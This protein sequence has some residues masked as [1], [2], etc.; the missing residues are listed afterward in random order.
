MAKHV[1]DI[2]DRLRHY[3]GFQDR[4]EREVKT[5]LR[6]LGVPDSH[7]ETFLQMLRDEGFLDEVR[8]AHGFARGKFRM[9]K[10]G[11]VLIRQGLRQKGVPEDL[12]QTAIETEID[13]EAYMDTLQ[14]LAERLGPAHDYAE[15]V[16]H[17]HALLRKGYEHDCI[18]KVMQE[19]YWE[20]VGDFSL[21]EE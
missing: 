14:L 10:W 16:K 9:S 2:P 21:G 20:S 18:S 11:R 5:K 15:K 17:R 1:Q 6:S 7:W 4:S 13:P 12:I 3:C 8:F 19:E